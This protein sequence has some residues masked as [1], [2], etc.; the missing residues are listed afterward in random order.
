[1]KEIAIQA[2]KEAGEILIENFGK[3][4]KVA[5]K[6]RGELVTNVDVE[7]ERRIIGLIKKNYPQHNI[8]A[9]ESNQPQQGNSDYRWIIDPLDGTLNY[10]RGIDT[11]G[12]SIALEYKKEVIL[13]VIY[14]PLS[15]QLYFAQKGEGSYLNG[16]RI[17]VSRTGL[18]EAYIVY[19]SSIR[20]DRKK[21][22]LN[23]L[24]KLTEQTF[25][26]RVLGSSARSL[27]YLAQGKVELVIDYYDKPWDFS[28]GALIVEEAGGRV[29]DMN[30][31]RWSPWSRGYIASNGIIHEKVLKIMSF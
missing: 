5:I 25:T 3:I 27:S 11:F 31:E 9:E 14:I 1:M 8:L 4:K 15:K 28:G 7:S 29:T 12:V 16:E 24:D 30:G 23:N 18:K 22:M 13:G 2:V 20:L 19:D 6:N 17:K 21:V 10:V 26:L